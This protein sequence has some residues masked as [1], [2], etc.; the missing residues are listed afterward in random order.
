ML[1]S[2]S[3]CFSRMRI[4]RARKWKQFILVYFSFDAET[5]TQCH[6]LCILLVK[7][8]EVLI[9][10]EGTWL[11][12][13]YWNKHQIILR[14]CEKTVSNTGRLTKVKNDASRICLVKGSSY[15]LTEHLPGPRR[16]TKCL[17]ALFF[18]TLL[19]IP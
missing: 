17:H 4:V 13:S 14:S 9:Q 10:R 1:F 2:L 19:I 12:P 8:Q 5:G 6:F 18:S 3:K 7:I 11:F 16:H 15:H